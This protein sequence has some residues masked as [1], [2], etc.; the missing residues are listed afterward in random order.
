MP[1][2]Q[3]RWAAGWAPHS[4]CAGHCGS[5]ESPPP[6]R[7]VADGYDGPELIT[8]CDRATESQLR[9]LVPGPLQ[10]KRT[11]V[12]MKTV[13]VLEGGHPRTDGPCIAGFVS[14]D[15]PRTPK[16]S[17]TTEGPGSW[18]VWAAA[19]RGP[20]RQQTRSLI[21]DRS[22]SGGGKSRSGGEGFLLH[23]AASLTGEGA[24]R[25]PEPTPEGTRSPITCQ[26]AH[27]RTPSHWGL[28]SEVGRQGT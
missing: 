21:A 19:D 15:A 12:T 20:G 6:P 23:R 8:S 16:P 28:G 5:S 7:R 11:G 22:R 10:K 14:E 9:G 18:S 2:V 25:A 17:G 26:R 1:G 27:H 13:W 24:P 4:S 3:G